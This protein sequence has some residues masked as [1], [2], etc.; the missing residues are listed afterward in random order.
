MRAADHLVDFGPG[1]G[2]K[3]GEVVAEGTLAK[4]AD[5]PRSLTG[6][7]LSGRRAIA[8]PEQ[9]KT[10]HRAE[11]Q[12]RRGAAAQPQEHR[13]RGPARAVRLRDGRE[14]VGQELPDRRHPPRRP[15]PRPQRRD[16]RAGPTR[17]DRGGRP[18]R[19]GHRH[20]PVA[21]RPHPALEPGHL[22]QAVRPDPRP[23]HPAARRQGARLQGGPVQLQRRGGPVRGVPGQRLEPP[24]DGLPRR[25]LGHLPGLRGEAVQPRDAPRPLQGQ[26]HQRRPG[27]GRPGG[28]GA[29]RQR[30]Q[31]RRDAPD[32]ARRRPR[33]PEA[34]PGVADALR[35]RGPADQARP[36][37]GQEGHRADP[38][39]P[40]RAD[41]RAALRGRPQAARRPARL[42]GAG[43]HGGRHRAQPRRRQDRRLDHRPRPRG[44]RGGRPRR[45]RGDARA[46]RAGVREPHR[47]RAAASPRGASRR[48]SGR[49]RPGE[50]GRQ[51]EPQVV[52][53]GPGGDRR[54]R[55]PAAQPQ[56]DRRRPSPAQDDRV[57]RAER[58]GQ[59]LARD[60]HPLCRGPAALRREPL[61]LRPPVPRAAPEAEGRA[62]QR[63]VAGRQHRAEDDEQEPAID[64]RHRHR[65]PRLPAH[66][67]GPARPAALPGAAAWRSA[68]RRP[69]RSSRRSSTCPRGRRST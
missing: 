3:G 48:R 14:R 35:R 19:Q 56:G 57:Q 63:P 43:Q 16:H 62:D 38:L 51:A 68:R 66:P 45:R 29:L 21:D 30:P 20:R 22:H 52:R 50:E 37:A 41:H 28:P 61:Q 15:G 9:R 7:Y 44:G 5:S 24:G 6:Q 69:T 33:L 13:R 58:V 53:G 31:D 2:V 39:H 65:D 18:A 49:Q 11:A 25:R 36:R 40:R 32:A 27:D 55:G 42:H 46:G 26:E 59:E 60:R 4:L 47:R 10:S 34:R 54:P 64:G 17:P 1:P 8:I 12:G 23:L 67:D